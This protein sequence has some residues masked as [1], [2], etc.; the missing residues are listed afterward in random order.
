MAAEDGDRR[1]P[2]AGPPAAGRRLIYADEPSNLNCL[3][4]WNSL[5]YLSRKLRPGKPGRV[6]V[7]RLIQGFPLC[8]LLL[9]ELL[10]N[11]RSVG[12][13]CLARMSSPALCEK[14]LYQLK[15]RPA[16]DR[17]PAGGS[18]RSPSSAPTT[19]TVPP[20]RQSSKCR[21]PVNSFS[22]SQARTR[23][24]PSASRYQHGPYSTRLLKL[25]PTVSPGS[26]SFFVG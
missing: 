18:L 23:G 17:G 15:G 14:F 5:N 16:A 25:R 2:P 8:L 12:P 9:G 19:T 21:S 7:S 24:C 22:F 3:E 4:A 26:Y 10:G 20:S 11:K 6:H 1:E 13:A